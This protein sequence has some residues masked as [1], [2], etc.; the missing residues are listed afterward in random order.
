[1]SVIITRYAWLLSLIDVFCL[2]TPAFES[3]EKS[4]I[5][6]EK[7]EHWKPQT[8]LHLQQKQ[9]GFLNDWLVISE[10]KSYCV[11]T[12]STGDKTN[13]F[14]YDNSELKQIL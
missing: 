7:K 3:T 12:Q 8:V 2:Y 4:I 6:C 11:T 9:K 10:R 1:M 13:L 5:L 14:T